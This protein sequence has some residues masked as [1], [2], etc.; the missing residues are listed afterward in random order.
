[1]CFL[2]LLLA[3]VIHVNPAHK[4]GPMNQLWGF[5]GYDEPNYTYTINGS[6]LIGELG[7]LGRKP[8]YIRTHFLL[9]TGDTQPALKWG[10]TNAYTED[11]NGN[12]IYDWSII[13]R[14]FDTY[15]HASA[16]PFVEIGFMPQALSTHP[17]PYRHEFPK[18]N[19]TGW[20]YPPR[21]YAKWQELIYQLAK[22]CGEKYGVA[23]ASSWFW[24][25][26]N[27]P[28]IAYWHG[29]PEEYDK[30]YDAAA[31]AVKR[32]LPQ[33]RVG[34]PASTGPA[35]AHARS[36]LQ[37][38][39]EHCDKTRPPLDFISFHAKGRPSMVDG[40]V[41]MNLTAE[42]ADAQQGFSV[43]RQFPK[44]ATLPIILSE[45]D[46][47]GCAACSAQQYPQNAYRN[48]PLY[49]TYTATALD[50]I[51]RAAG[52]SHVNLA[53]MLTWAFEFEAQPYFAGFRDLAT[54]GIDK[55]ILNL[56]RMLGLMQTQRVESDQ[57]IATADE[58]GI[59]VLL[60]NYSADDLPGEATRIDLDVSGMPGRT[61]LQHYRIDEAH[62]NAYSTWQNMGSPQNPTPGQYTE[63]ERA[64]H[65][66]LIESPRWISPR[67]ARATVSFD[68]PRNAVSLV[69]FSW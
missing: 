34:G 25:V 37:Q 43:V 11:A 51:S 20:S 36:F 64:G 60:W 16:K 39:L 38:F 53:G 54:N 5:F 56:F 9:A 2:G 3:T 50:T 52:M 66:Q 35:S 47:E 10:S 67:N 27:E 69:Q 65:L 17:E 12:P 15:I 46:P 6:K 24:E 7:A 68:L 23:E 28:D 29:T 40:H 26:W 48:G 21:D 30:L 1:M 22:H 19:F 14:I 18:S 13:D 4:L 58:H 33:A 57:G 59:S 31:A 55:P 41:Q 63:L 44:F 61:L 62:S 49:A 32:A 45:A 42:V 8:V